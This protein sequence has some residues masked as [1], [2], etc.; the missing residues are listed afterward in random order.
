MVRLGGVT[1]EQARR[2]CAPPMQQQPWSQFE[3]GRTRINWK[4]AHQ[5]APALF[6]DLCKT[7]RMEAAFRVWLVWFKNVEAY[8]TPELQTYAAALRKDLLNWCPGELWKYAERTSGQVTA[9]QAPA[10]G[11]AAQA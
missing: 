2:K 10:T 3:L 5:I 9:L 1:Q 6:E 4:K 7:D 11:G 8:G